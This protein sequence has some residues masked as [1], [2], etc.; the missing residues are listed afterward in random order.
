MSEEKYSWEVKEF[1]KNPFHVP[2][3]YFDHL[4]DR[5][6]SHVT[7][8]P[9]ATATVQHRI[10]RPWMVWVTSAAAVL[11]MGWFGFQ[12]LYLKPHQEALF[13]EGVSLFVDYYAQE[14]HAGELADYIAD[15]QIDLTTT[16][17]VDYNYLIQ[18]EPEMTEE[19]IYES[20]NY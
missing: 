13:Q 20:I 12:N 1:N 19:M 3:G 9:G 15:Q 2:D 11:I 18:I 6:L 14:L 7:E 10:I 16:S 17:A 4:S 8:N 5:I